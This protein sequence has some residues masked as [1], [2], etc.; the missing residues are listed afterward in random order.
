MA[1]SMTVASMAADVV[2]FNK[3][4]VPPSSDAVVTVPFALPAVGSFTANGKT[5]TGITIAGPLTAHAFEGVFYIRMTSGAAVGRWSTISA[6]TATELTLADTTFLG[7]VVATDTFAIIPHQTLGKVFPDELKGISFLESSG[8]SIH[9]TEVYLPDTTTISINKAPV[10]SYFY[11]QGN[12]KRTGSPYPISND[13]ILPP[14][15]YFKLRNKSATASLMFITTG[16]TTSNAVQARDVR[17]ESAKNDIPAASGNATTVSLLDLKLGGTA[18]FVTSTGTSLHKDEL[19]VYVNGGIGINAAPSLTY[20][21]YN[22]G[23]RK[24]G[25]A[26]LGYPDRGSDVLPAGAALFIRKAAGT[27]GDSVWTEPKAE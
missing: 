13:V 3:V 26:A 6:N 15:S 8:T 16:K 22:N 23:W 4:A 2:G 24:V 25:D 20:F 19:W 17:T 1:A 27:P 12:W 21:Y 9:S 18:A 14:D 7:S 11:H 5:G 10:V